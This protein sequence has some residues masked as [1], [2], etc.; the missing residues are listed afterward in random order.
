MT[1]YHIIHLSQKHNKWLTCDGF[2]DIMALNSFPSLSFLVL[3]KLHLIHIIFCFSFSFPILKLII[4]VPHFV[5]QNLML[6]TAFLLVFIQTFPGLHIE[7]LT[8]DQPLGNNI[9]RTKHLSFWVCGA[10]IFQPSCI[11]EAPRNYMILYAGLQLLFSSSVRLNTLN[12][13]CKKTNMLPHQIWV[14]WVL[15][16][17]S[18]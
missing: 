6:P 3:G 18:S 5:V 15:Y 4:L 16:I 9:P 13:L 12:L 1:F 17:V 11:T 7:V 10:N 2:G 14:S 8:S